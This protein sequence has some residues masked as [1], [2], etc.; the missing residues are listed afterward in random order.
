MRERFGRGERWR[1]IVAATVVAVGLGAAAPA[2]AAAAD[3]GAATAA[4]TLRDG[5]GIRV[6]ERSAVDDRQLRL[7]VATAALRQ[8]VEVRVLLPDGYAR[9]PDRR[10]PVLYLFHGTGGSAAD[11]VQAGD[12]EK[13]T[14]G[15]DL[16]VVMPDAGYGDGGGW[17]ADWMNPEPD[18]T[19]K[20]ETFHVGQLVPW[21]DGGLRTRARR[22]GRA[23][24]GLSQGGFGA[25]TYAARH[26]D[27]F[28]SVASFSGAPEIT[29]DPLVSVGALAIVE[30]ITVGLNG[31]PYGS[32]FGDRV[33]NAINWQGHDPGMLVENLRGMWIG[34]WT[35]SGLPGDLDAPLALLTGLPSVLI[36]QLTHVSTQAFK[37]HLDEAGIPSFYDDYVFGTHVWP[38]WARDLRAYVGPLMR[39]F[40]SPPPA[41]ERVSYHSIDRVWAQ[42][43]WR[44]EL[45]RAAAQEFSALAA[46]DRH[47]FALTGT[48]TAVVTTPPVYA[49]GAV[50]RVRVG[51]DP[52]QRLRVDDRGRLR[53]TLALGGAGAPAT[54][55]VT[56]AAPPK[57]A[58]PAATA[59]AAA[60]AVCRPGRRL[61]VRVGARGVRLRTVRATV[62]GRR[63][64][65]R[66]AGG[67][68]VRVD[69][70]GRP[71]GR[72]TVRVTARTSDGRTLRA[73]RRMRTC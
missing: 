52:E 48:G 11:W 45:T 4:T 55:R 65:A 62:G 6:V 72:R 28:S 71:A 16:I 50:A 22:E 32:V 2:I 15:R 12:V 61:T 34:L 33:A 47:G 31:K 8:P 27:M 63:V 43:G 25:M 36:E 37:R 13:T 14:A 10:Y 68:R 21:I 53:M 56:I 51:D 39:T 9:H 46:A 38:Y 24:A 5:H 23:I 40:D 35:A 67:N 54:T 69:V 19:P 29:R 66:R 26:P 44:V 1:R 18:G 64:R 3:G 17:F 30:A 20:W 57:P 58:A 49:P 60:A 59:P 73:T 7:K 42:W 41:P 70:G